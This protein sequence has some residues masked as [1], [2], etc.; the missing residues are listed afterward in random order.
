MLSHQ[1][2]SVGVMFNSS[3]GWG[4]PPS[5][6]PSEWLEYTFAQQLF[7]EGETC[8]GIA[9]CNAKDDIQPLV[10]VPLIDWVTQE[11]NLLGDPALT[12]I[13][14][15]TGIEGSGAST[16]MQ[17]SLSAPYPNPT[18]SGCSIGYDLP[19]SA[20]VDLT[21]YDISGRAVRNIYSG[22]LAQGQGSVAFDGRDDSGNPLPSG[23]YT[24]VMSGSDGV[25]SVPMMVLR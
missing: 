24:V 21:V 20:A 1:G 13:T 22:R 3:Y 18:S 15:Q 10:S 5:R 12:F 19:A 14:G 8:L 9:Q 6:G 16:A 4:T 17:P 11:N 7:Q 25:T 23:C 2:G